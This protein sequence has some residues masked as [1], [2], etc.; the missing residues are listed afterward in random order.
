MKSSQYL[1]KKNAK[2]LIVIALILVFMITMITILSSNNK[3]STK[4]KITSSS[5][6]V[7]RTPAIVII[8]PTGLVPQTIEIK[9]G[10]AVV[11]T[12]QDKVNHNVSSDDPV[13][14]FKSV[15]DIKPNSTFSYIF[16]KVGTYSYHDNTNSRFFGIIRVK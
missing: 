11:W 12:N 6:F 2:F 7:T 14:F 16:D 4:N 15:Q 13:P 3:Q 10:Q 8:S 5:S 9:Q 1:S